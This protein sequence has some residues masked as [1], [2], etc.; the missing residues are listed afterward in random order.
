MRSLDAFRMAAGGLRERKMRTALTILGIVI[1]SS[2]IVALFASTQGQSAAIE[3]QLGRLGPTTLIVRTTG[4]TR[5]DAADLDKLLADERVETAFL[6]INGNA[7]TT[8]AGIAGSSTVVGIEPD[9][10]GTLVKGLQVLEGDLFTSDQLSAAFIGYTV[11][12]PDPAN[13][14]YVYAG[15]FITVSTTS[16]Q[17]GRGAQTTARSLQVTGIA[18]EFGSAPYI[19]VDNTIFVPVATAQQ[20]FRINP[21]QYNQIIVIATDATYV[22]ALQDEFPTILDKTVLVLSGTQLASTIT[23]VYDTIGSLL[24]SVA[25]ISLIVAGVGI[26]NTMFVSVLE[27]ITEIGT[28]KALGFKAREVLSIFLLE[29]SLTGLIGGIV[30]CVAGVGIAF[31]IGEAI[32]SSTASASPSSPTGGIARGAGGG[33]APGGAGGGFPGGGGGGGAGG[34]GGG[35]AG[36]FG[37]GGGGAPGGGGTAVN[38]A[39]SLAVDADPVFTPELFL[40]AI[41]FA[42]IIALVAGLIPSRKAAKLDPV[43]AL[44]RL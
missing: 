43:I 12:A 26:A 11:G 24:T 10:I 25:A 42:V 38:N 36:G 9:D 21:G 14:T 16:F 32:A 17:Q 22:D 34:F 39:Q 20:L 18:A 19:D 5:F 1:G 15:D 27:R 23:G 8:R 29:A 7:Q 30:G 28:L 37:G 2:M 4:Q 44:K 6:S 13:N 41:A 40:M 31:G 3:E 33:A 35:G